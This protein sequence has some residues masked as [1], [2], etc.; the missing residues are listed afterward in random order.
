MKHLQQCMPGHS[1]QYQCISI[2]MHDP[3]QFHRALDLIVKLTSPQQQP[4]L[5]IEHQLCCSCYKSSPTLP[6]SN[7]TSTT[8][9]HKKQQLRVASQLQQ[10]RR[11]MAAA[12]ART[13][14]CCCCCCRCPSHPLRL[15]HYKLSTCNRCTGRSPTNLL[16]PILPLLLPAV[17]HT[18]K[19]CS[20][21]CQEANLPP[22]KQHH[23]KPLLATP[24]AAAAA[25]A[26]VAHPLSNQ[27]QSSATERCC[28]PAAQMLVCGLLLVSSNRQ[29]AVHSRLGMRGMPSLSPTCTARKET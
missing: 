24:A 29:A 27:V 6:P 9:P 14:C 15:P 26:A 28:M 11:G 16:A 17:A 2:P 7:L 8:H 5:A 10:Q 21:S 20:S 4:K 13:C 18:S 23:Q 12:I 25:A 3:T 1:H 19:G 22:T